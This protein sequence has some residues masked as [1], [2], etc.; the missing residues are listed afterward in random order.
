M[1]LSLSL[2]LSL[3]LSSAPSPRPMRW[4]VVD[5]CFRFLAGL[6]LARGRKRT[7]QRAG[8]RGGFGGCGFF[9]LAG[10]WLSLARRGEAAKLL[11][12]DDGGAR[13]C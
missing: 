10:L 5:R 13:G 1:S 11:L 6:G 2:S 4:R 3:G 12:G 7:L 8:R 9:A